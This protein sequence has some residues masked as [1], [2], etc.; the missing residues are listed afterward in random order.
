MGVVYLVGAGCGDY[1]L[2]TMRGYE[3]IKKCD[4]LV[5]DSLIDSKF[6][7]F[8]K[9]NCEKIPVGKRAGQKS[10][11]QEDINNIL[12]TKGKENNIVVRF[13]GGDPFVFGRGGEEI[14][15]LK[16]N[17]IPYEVVP[18]ITSSVAV[19]ELSGI[20]VTHRKT[21]RSFTVITGHTKDDLLPENME[22]FAK[23]KGTL[24]F[25]M[26]LN[27]IEK[28]TQSLIANGKD[29]S[30]PSAVISNGATKN[31]VVVKGTLENIA[32]KVK[33]NNV[34]SPAII[35]VGETSSY[36]FSRTIKLP[37]DS[38]SVTVTGTKRFSE[39]LQQKLYEKGASVTHLNYLKVEKYNQNRNLENALKNLSDYSLI[40]LTSINGAEIFFEKLIE[41]KIDVRKLSNIKF[42]VIGSGT[43]KT[44]E[45]HG[46]IPDLV[47][48]EFTSLAL[49]NLIAKTYENGKVLILRAEK[50][51]KDLTEVL[52]KNN[53][54]YDDIKTYDVI[55]SSKSMEKEVTTDYITF[56][57]SSGV[58]EFFKNN[59]TISERTKIVSI[60]NITS[61]SLLKHNVKDFITSK[62]A[63]TNGLLS[64]IINDV[65]FRK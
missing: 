28:I 13:K 14:I 30:T 29:K 12:V 46:I 38:T 47:P 21:A 43:A 19:P 16:E 8:V 49:G 40:V 44:M 63:D 53:I 2:I 55:N 39:K 31:Q 54:D 9:D 32:E 51:S 4:V 20:P 52:S 27:N 22:H 48:A 15:S 41:Y 61:K 60:G 37:L 24:V 62:V 35:T 57:S 5:Y 58:E 23:L 34:K 18:G 1:D 11:K 26:G 56:A 7:D 6:L 17:N 33:E 50:G 45:N 10:A 3:L 59:F 65:K 25:L 42:A 36:D 64:A